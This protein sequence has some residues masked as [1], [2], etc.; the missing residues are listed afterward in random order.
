MKIQSTMTDIL[1]DSH[2]FS[3]LWENI[4]SEKRAK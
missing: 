3:H 4:M 2:F 1:F